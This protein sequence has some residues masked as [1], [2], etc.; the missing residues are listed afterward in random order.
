MYDPDIEQEQAEIALDSIQHI[1]AEQ[2]GQ[3]LDRFLVDL[4]KDTSRTAIQQLIG[5]GLV[6]VNGKA[7]KAGYA[8]RNGDRVQLLAF[9]ASSPDITVKPQAIPLDV[10]YEDEDIIV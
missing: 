7:S 10:V 3:R 9:A 8:L 1:G 4:L 5:D 2:A 6:L